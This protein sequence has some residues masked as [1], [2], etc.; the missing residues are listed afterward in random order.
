MMIID[1]EEE[2]K[3]KVQNNAVTAGGEEKDKEAKE[4]KLGMTYKN[5]E[6]LWNKSAI[7]K[8][9]EENSAYSI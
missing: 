4:N 9:R 5:V 1:D 6:I 3:R 7:V 8:V 2:Y